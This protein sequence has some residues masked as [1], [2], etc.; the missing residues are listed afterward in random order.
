MPDLAP[1]V[2]IL[3]AALPPGQ[4]GLL[5]HLSASSSGDEADLDLGL[6]PLDGLHPLDLLEGT[7]APPAWLALGLVSRGWASPWD[8]TRPSH[9]PSR[10]PVVATVLAD[11][12]GRFV[13]RVVA[14]DGTVI[15]DEAPSEGAVAA[16]LLAAL[17]P[18]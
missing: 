11:R 12:A 14:E 13:G 16:A 9:H 1:W 10:V 18:A 4:N 6:L 15:V 3:E 17:L 7:V 8:G 2:P 5:V